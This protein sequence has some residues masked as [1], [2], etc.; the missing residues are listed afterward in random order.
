[1]ETEITLEQALE[2]LAQVKKE[3]R[4]A[5]AQYGE[6]G[7]ENGAETV[8]E[9]IPQEVTTKTGKTRLEYPT[10]HP[11]IYTSPDMHRGEPTIRGSRITVRNIV[12]W[13]RLGQTPPEILE[14]YPHLSL[15][16][17]YDAI[18]YYYDHSAEIDQYIRENEEAMWR[19]THRASI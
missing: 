8:T 16:I 10:D 3:L 9:V 11:H 18:A 15:A 19:L 1:M 2:E 12:E 17:I 14:G 6:V 7:V 5:K 13:M 4:E